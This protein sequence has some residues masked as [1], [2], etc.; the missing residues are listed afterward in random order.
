VSNQHLLL[1]KD[2]DTLVL[3]FKGSAQLKKDLKEEKNPWKSGPKYLDPSKNPFSAG[4]SGACKKL[5]F[6]FS[7]SDAKWWSDIWTL[8]YLTDLRWQ[9]RSVA[10]L[11]AERRWADFVVSVPPSGAIPLQPSATGQQHFYLK[12]YAVIVHSSISESD[13]L[14]S[15]FL[16]PTSKIK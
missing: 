4:V 13:W 9:E 7:Q 12:A 11:G 10:E 14:N 3:I 5:G 1:L 16:L 6:G 8:V 15:I 2:Q